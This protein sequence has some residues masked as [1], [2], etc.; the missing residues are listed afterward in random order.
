MTR[1]PQFP[2]LMSGLNAAGHDPFA[3]ACEAARDGVDAGLILYDLSDDLRAALICA[4]EVPLAQAVA[5]LPLCGVGVQNALGA[6]APPEVPVH[7]D[8]SGVIRVNGGRCGALRM[9][10]STR[11]PE[12]IPDWLVVG[13]AL[14][15]EAT[16][17]DQGNTPDETALYAEGCGELTPQDMLESWARHTLT[18][19]HRWEQEGMTP[20]HREWSGLLHGL[21]RPVTIAGRDGTFLGVDE[22]LGMLLKAEGT[23]HLIPLTDLLETQT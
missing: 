3:A 6:L 7:L 9:A 18:W 1:A 19:I 5:M 12:V 10:A 4:P 2:P 13:Y 8:W 22:N 23:T 16:L 20:L 21:G 17:Q 14:R 15:F 11:D